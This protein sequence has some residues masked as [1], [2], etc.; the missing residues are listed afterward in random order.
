MKTTRKEIETYLLEL[1]FNPSHKG[2]VFLLCVLSD[3]VNKEEQINW[4]IMNL[5]SRTARKYATSIDAVERAVRYAMNS[6]GVKFT[7]KEFCIRTYY[8][9]QHNK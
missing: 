9:F 3:V 5:Y 2:F 1:N 7:T 4:K 8:H 6:A